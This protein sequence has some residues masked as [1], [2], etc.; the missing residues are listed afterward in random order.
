M[1]TLAFVTILVFASFLLELG[2]L[3]VDSLLQNPEVWLKRK[4]AFYSN[5]SFDLSED[6]IRLLGGKFSDFQKGHLPFWFH[7]ELF[8]K[9]FKKSYANEEEELA[10]EHTY[11]KSCIRLL[12]A[13]VLYRITNPAEARASETLIAGETLVGS[14]AP[15]VER[16]ADMVSRETVCRLMGTKEKHCS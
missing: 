3:Q 16:D 7:F 6:N 13:R 11:I 4:E 15:V 8:K 5:T 14:K 10:R 9:V 2:G 1:K 12:K